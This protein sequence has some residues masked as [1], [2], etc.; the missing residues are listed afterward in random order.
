MNILW[1]FDGTL[2]DT[3]PAYTNM[4]ADVLGERDIYK[5][6]KISY[7]HALQHYKISSE[8]QEELNKL[9]AD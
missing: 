4:L 9:K 8:Q 2:F 5:Q 3:Y 1:D 7:S 6:L